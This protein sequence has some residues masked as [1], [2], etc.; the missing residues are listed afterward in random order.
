MNILDLNYLESA[1]TETIEGGYYYLSS[2]AY[3]DAGGIGR[4]VSSGTSAST[5]ASV[6]YFYKSTYASTSGYASASKGIVASSSY[7]A[8]S[9]SPGYFPS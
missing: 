9:I 5:D 1:E 4:Y 2:I 6:G 7:A 8:S 3:S